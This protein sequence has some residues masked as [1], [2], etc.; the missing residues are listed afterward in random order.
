M[1]R[2]KIVEKGVSSYIIDLC[3]YGMYIFTT[4]TVLLCILVYFGSFE[5]DVSAAGVKTVLQGLK[6]AH[7]ILGEGSS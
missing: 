6:R 7:Y 5:V 2:P 4:R 1:S 3:S